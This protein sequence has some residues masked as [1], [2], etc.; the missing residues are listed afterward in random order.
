MIQSWQNTLKRFPNGS[1]CCLLSQLVT[2]TYCN[3]FKASLIRSLYVIVSS[4]VIFCRSSPNLLSFSKNIPVD[5]LE[6]PLFDADI[7]EAG[8]LIFSYCFNLF[9]DIT[10]IN[11]NPT[12]WNNLKFK[13]AIFSEYKYF[14]WISTLSLNIKTF[15]G[16]K[17]FLWIQ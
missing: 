12:I 14:L 5:F 4:G 8:Q 17:S 10:Y 11:Q 1:R 7:V 13:F 16:H 15:S 9:I 6:G 2:F 3:S